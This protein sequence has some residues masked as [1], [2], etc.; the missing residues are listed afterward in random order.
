MGEPD[1]ENSASWQD[2]QTQFQN[3]RAFFTGLEHVLIA[4]YGVQP[5]DW[6]RNFSLF[7]DCFDTAAREAV[8]HMQAQEGL[9]DMYLEHIH[10]IEPADETSAL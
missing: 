4:Q 9:R 1:S 7:L 8:D 5:G 10:S 6:Q 2:F 3:L